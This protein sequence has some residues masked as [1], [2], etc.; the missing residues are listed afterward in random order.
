MDLGIFFCSWSSEP[1][2]FPFTTAAGSRNHSWHFLQH[3]FLNLFS[4]PGKRPWAIGPHPKKPQ[5]ASQ[6][7]TW[8]YDYLK[9]FLR[10]VFGARYVHTLSGGRSRN[11]AKLHLYLASDYLKYL[12]IWWIQF[13]HFKTNACNCYSGLLKILIFIFNWIFF[14]GFL[15][16]SF[17]I[18]GYQEEYIT[19]WM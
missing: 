18:K 7:Q 14:N 10:F 17:H 13:Q 16:G 9:L 3:S 15:F 2:R 1:E 8:V 11:I 6:L 19:M 5:S 4:S 12:L